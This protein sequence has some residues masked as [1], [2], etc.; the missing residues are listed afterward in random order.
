M[1]S[2]DSY[3]P[4]FVLFVLGVAFAALSLV[5]SRLLAPK[6]PTYAKEAPY[7]SGIIPTHD[8]PQRFPVRFYLVAMIFVIFDIEVIFLFPWA[9]VYDQLGRFGLV[10]I[11]VFAAAVFFSFIYLIAN[12]A[13]DWGPTKRVRPVPTPTSRTSSSTVRRVSGS[14]DEAA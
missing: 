11:I 14:D 6:R 12:G 5:A 10:E 1:G 8:L 2:L 9:V 7:E 3:L 4:I 13:L